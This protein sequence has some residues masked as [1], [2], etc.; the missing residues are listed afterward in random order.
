MSLSTLILI[1]GVVLILSVFI[2]KATYKLGIPLL[3]L[4]LTLGIIFGNSGFKVIEFTSYKIPENIAS[5]ALMVIIFAGGF[6]TKWKKAKNNAHISIIL[7]SV[8]VV[9]TALIV[10]VFAHFVLKF[11]WLVSLLIGAIISSTD[12]A[13]VFSILRARRLNLKNDIGPL[14]EMESGSND[15]TAYMIT[16]IIIGIILN[17]SQNILLNFILQIAV[18]LGI[19]ALVGYLG[20]L[21]INNIK[22][23]VDGLY[24]ILGLALMLLSFG[25]TVKLLGNGYL[26]VYLT[27]IIIGN[28]KLVYKSNY[29]QFYDSFSWL[30]Q[31]I[32]FF[33]LGAYIDISLFNMSIILKG[34]G[35]ALFISFIAR[36]LA[37]IPI[38]KLLKKPLK[39]SMLVSWVG[40]RGAASIVFAFMAMANNPTNISYNGQ[41]I[42]YIVFVVAVVSVLLQ[43]L[44]LV[45]VAKKLD[46]V[47]EEDVELHLFTNYSG[48]IFANTLEVVIH[49]K[50]IYLNKKIKDLNLLNDDVLVLFVKRNEEIIPPNGEFTVKLGDI[51][52]ITSTNDDHLYELMEYKNT[53]SI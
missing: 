12:A 49:E 52:I 51:L 44:L 33:A 48:S 13:A 53:H 11:D 14:L 4:F 8:G 22:L 34:L 36:P 16:M 1:A 47:E 43:G 27:G 42:L 20:T 38:M 45:P 29:S 18:G 35:I 21:I 31:I 50:S 28:S 17:T 40:F 26:A 10:G 39:D 15:P 37:V 23:E 32:L 7:A 5:F 19:G 25:L 41:E 6:D 46:L 24:V 2:T 3:I 30:A 9:L